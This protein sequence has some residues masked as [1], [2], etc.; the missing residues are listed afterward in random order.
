MF[1]IDRRNL[2]F[3]SV[4]LVDVDIKSQWQAYFHG[5]YP[6]KMDELPKRHESDKEVFKKHW[7]GNED[8]S[9]EKFMEK[10]YKGW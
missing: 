2:Q 6:L 4:S 10:Y 9:Y 1:E 3:F 5:A 7:K 8:I